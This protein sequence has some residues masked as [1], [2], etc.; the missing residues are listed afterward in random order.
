MRRFGYLLLGI[1]PILTLTLLFTHYPVRAAP[2]ADIGG[3]DCISKWF[4]SYGGAT[5]YVQVYTDTEGIPLR[6]LSFSRSYHDPRDTAADGFL[7][8]DGDQK[9]D[10]FTAVLGQDGLWQWRY[11]SGG[12]SAW[13][14]MG[15]GAVPPDELRF[16][17]FNND[18]ITDVFWVADPGDGYPHWYYSPGGTDPAV[19]LAYDNRLIQDLRFG[20]FDGNGITDVF[21]TQP[22]V[23]STYEWLIS[24]GANTNYVR[25]NEADSR[26]DLFRFGDMNGDGKT[27]VIS[28]ILEP[29][30]RFLWVYSSAATN[31]YQTIASVDFSVS[32]TQP[33]D[34]N[35]DNYTDLFAALGGPPVWQ[36]QYVRIQ[37]APGIDLL[38]IDGTPPDQ[39][40]FA[41]F[42]NDEKTDVF[43]LV[44]ECTTPE[45]KVFLPLTQK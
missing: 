4:V 45:M 6:D 19:E 14:N 24:Y 20:D 40:R 35:G 32:L 23:R 21:V 31:A 18:G 25:V 22:T 30:G 11:A 2:T 38:A 5:N 36:W 33:G 9:N 15:K 39:L 10:I 34:F 43:T 3:G 41:D 12:N 28:E 17:N 26:P 37:P 16:G 42:D 8:F 13:V 44:R 27:D 29:N 7:D 1:F